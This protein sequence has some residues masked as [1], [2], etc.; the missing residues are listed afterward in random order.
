[1]TGSLTENRP[2]TATE[3]QCVA[4]EHNH[5]VHP[6]NLATHTKHTRHREET[7]SLRTSSS[8]IVI[9]PPRA[10]DSDFTFDNR[11]QGPRRKRRHSSCRPMPNSRP[12]ARRGVGSSDFDDDLQ[13]RKLHTLQRRNPRIRSSGIVATSR[14]ATAAPTSPS[15]Q[16]R[17]VT[18]DM[19]RPRSAQR[20]HRCHTTRNASTTINLKSL[21]PKQLQ[22]DVPKRED[23]TKAPPSTDH[24]GSRGFPGASPD[25]VMEKS[26]LHPL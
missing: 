14:L 15:R 10:S 22:I 12:Q 17:P 5:T 2:K 21:R 9:T 25:R 23:D 24:E 26:G 11:Q 1:L 20:H 3:H 13:R 18:K 4:K 6:A 8:V 16:G 7:P 19:P